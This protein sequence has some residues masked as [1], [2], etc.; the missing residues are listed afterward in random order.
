MKVVLRADVPDVG[1]RGD[2]VDVADGYGRNFLLARGLGIAASKGA[3]AQAE[4]MKRASAKRDL[5]DREAAQRVS[6]LLTAKA[7][8]IPARAGD[9]GRLFGSVTSVAIAEAV[10]AQTGVE[11]DRRK[12]VLDEPIRS[13]GVHT[14]VVKLHSTVETTITLE[15]V[16]Q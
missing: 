6:G 4:T 7:I 1:A 16:V 3:V 13:L 9:D 12:L 5:R 11:L 8:R 10:E 2:V 14:V 15:V